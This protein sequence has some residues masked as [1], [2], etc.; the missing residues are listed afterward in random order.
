MDTL[1]DFLLI[2]FAVFFF[3]AYLMV[4][5]TVLGDL[6]R[7]S[8]LSGWAK[9]A[10]I[11]ALIFLPLLT[12][13]VYFITRG[14]GMQERAIAQAKEIQAAQQEY[15]REAAGTAG[16]AD[17]IATAKTLLDSG[18]ISQAEFDAIKVKALS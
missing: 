17:Q 11:V 12:S 18:A 13:L 9:A 14:K 2:T 3:F 5:W 7:D 1:T 4:L 16:P 8:S 15:I 10:W 6:F